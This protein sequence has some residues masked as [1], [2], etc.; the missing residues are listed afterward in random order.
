MSARSVSKPRQALPEKTKY[1]ELWYIQLVN[2]DALPSLYSLKI[3]PAQ[4]I[5]KEVGKI[6]RFEW[7]GND[8]A[9]EWESLVDNE[10]THAFTEDP[11]Q[12][13]L[14]I[15][16][17]L[18]PID[19]LCFPQWIMDRFKEALDQHVRGQWLSSISLCGDIVEF[20]VNEFWFAYSE[21][22]PGDVRKTPSESTEKNLKA[23]AQYGI[24]DAKDHRRL[25][26]VR[27]TRDGHVHYHLRN[28]LLSDYSQRLKVDNIEVLRKLSQFFAVENMQSKYGH[29]LDFAMEQFTTNP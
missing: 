15:R 14:A 1:R 10:H 3:T 27:Q 6:S 22:L 26:E 11:V 17:V 21:K 2:E 20:I 12:K 5:R 23:L 8:I 28:R 7:S 18:Q 16:E 19:I 13:L 25:L 9:I 29:Y 24:I 4:Q